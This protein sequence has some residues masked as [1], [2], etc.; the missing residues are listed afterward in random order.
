MT[1]SL[2]LVF[3][4]YH[5]SATLIGGV[6][7]PAEHDSF[8]HARRIIDAIGD[9]LRMAQFDQHMH[10]PE[11]SW[12]TWPWAYDMLMACLAK[13][14]MAL[15]GAADPMTVLAPVAPAWVV[16][17]AALFLGICQRLRLSPLMRALAM[18]FFAISP[19]T[20]NLHRV[21]MLDHHF[22]EYTFV[23]ASLLLGLGWFE[24]LSGRR[25]AV[26]LGIVLGAA[27][28]F[29]NG[30][31]ILQLPVLLTLAWLW[32]IRRPID[33]A[34]AV[35]FAVAL[36]AATAVFL[37]PSEPFRQGQFSYYLHSG[38]HFYVA[39]CTA[40]LCV[41]AAS[42]R[43]TSRTAAALGA[44][45]L[46]MALPIVPQL[47]LGRDFLL[48]QIPFMERIIET[49]SIAQ[50]VARSGW[51]VVTLTYSPLLW[52]MPLAIAGLAWQLRRDPSNAR[53]YF[54][55][56]ALLGAALMLQTLRM[57]YFGSFALILPVCLLIDDLRLQRPALFASRHRVMALGALG[58]A[59]ILPGLA[60]LRAQHPV[61]TDNWYMLTRDM[62]PV[63]T[64][65]CRKDPGVVLADPNDGHYIRYH[66][67]CA[68][69][70]NNFL[71]T[72]QHV[73]KVWFTE[74]LLAGSA[75]EGLRQ[76]PYVRYIFIKRADNL[77]D[78]TRKCG[79][80]CPENAG[81]RRELLQGD[82]MREPGPVYRLRLKMELR[83]QRGTENIP[84]ARLFEVRPP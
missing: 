54:F 75:A 45:L 55:V 34:A 58:A 32:A 6:F 24:D 31:F 57:H 18:L 83:M 41:M 39:G 47:E 53:L 30:L 5:L 33:R 59:L 60:S 64:D 9:P 4:F 80:L 21:G 23:L 19:L 72:P 35:S 82:L 61:G 71:T 52:L 38:F 7:V 3:C 51:L 84:V 70:G 49:R 42:L 26:A 78:Q 15:T 48:T 25:R 13:G 8:Y 56:Q 76:A 16:V 1:S 43:A 37:V 17:N 74:Q 79:L 29:Q 67:E 14:L 27:P 20:Q 81:M 11:G 44:V 28:A 65:A 66:S 73:Q 77:M 2:A 50:A 12:I 62:Y 36:L 40:V 22:I 63:L 46:A 69:I 68:V 10:A